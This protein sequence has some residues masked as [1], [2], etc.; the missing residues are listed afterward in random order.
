VQ[1]QQLVGCERQSVT[2]AGQRIGRDLFVRGGRSLVRRHASGFRRFRNGGRA[3]LATFVGGH[4]GEH[5]RCRRDRG[6]RLGCHFR[7]GIHRQQRTRKDP[8]VDVDY[9]GTDLPD[10]PVAFGSCRQP[11]ELVEQI[12]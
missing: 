5:S 9:S 4:R 1:G 3:R 11:L 8:S 7:V 10:Y 6:A 12:P 2:G